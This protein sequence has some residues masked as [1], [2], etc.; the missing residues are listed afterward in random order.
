MIKRYTSFL[1]LPARDPHDAHRVSTPLEL[2]FDLISV[3]AIAAVTAGLHHAI[4]EGHGLDKLPI[5]AFLFIAIWWAWMNFTWFASAF[6]NDGP[7]YRTLVMVLM[8]GEV[9][10][11][12]GAAYMFQSGDFSWGI[13]GWTIMRIAMA[14]LWL[15]AAANPDYR[16]T[17]L[18]YAFGVLFAQVLWIAFYFMTV[19]GTALFYA[20][21]IA[22]FLVEFA[23]PVFAE[24]ARQTPFHRHHIIERY[25]L[26]TIISLGEVILA[27]SLGFGA[28]Y[29]DHPSIEPVITAVA[30]LVLVFCLFGLYFCEKEHLPSTDFKTAFTWGY[31][32]V[33]IYA[34]IAAIGA[35]VAAELD[36]A[37]HHSHV[38]QAD[39]AWWMGGP[40]ALFLFGLW[41][42]RDR[43]R[44]LS[45]RGLALPVMAG[46]ALIAAALGLPSWAFAV[47]GLAALIW[48]V[49]PPAAHTT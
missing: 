15:R 31:G 41:F 10:F 34:A 17:C 49:P 29:G 27:I 32:H 30:A 24:Q 14:A 8:G 43:L 4:S 33:L 44:S 36:L 16:T 46:I 40:L 26:L 42:T 7:F 39:V 11:A 48:R 47:I 12:G 13:L 21:G 5:F 6:D 38:S 20:A 2:F 19:P 3:I 37:M 1:P 22:I 35:G 9:M 28:L 18:R 45:W 25:G 23:V